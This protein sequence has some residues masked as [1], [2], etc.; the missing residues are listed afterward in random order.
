MSVRN[1]LFLSAVSAALAVAGVSAAPALAQAAKASF[2]AGAQVKDTQGGDVGTI[3]RVDGD[4]VIVKTDK[5]EVRLPQ[6]SFTA[7]EGHFLMAMTRDQLN[8]EVDKALAAANA[9]LVTGATV[10]GSAGSPVGTIN[11]IDDQF[12]TIK[13]TSGA[14]VRLPRSGIAAGP[15]GPVI[16]MTGEQL[17]AQVGP[18]GAP[19]AEGEGASE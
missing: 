19:A 9:K 18:A 5:H 10:L 17:Q 8:A 1:K 3:T 15:N 16:G 2:A 14:L 13:L 6:A 7:H 11:A 12:V 4:H